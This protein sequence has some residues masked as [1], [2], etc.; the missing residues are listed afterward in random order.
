[1]ILVFIVVGAVLVFAIAAAFVGREAFRL[2]HTPTTTVFD[3][4]EAVVYVAERLSDDA[5][6]GLT[7]DEVKLLLGFS[8]D[9]LR[10]KGLSARPGEEIEL[11]PTGPPVVVA[12]D[13]AVALVLGR[14]DEAELVVTDMAVLE[15]LDLLL[16]HLVDIGAVGP[17]V[18]P[19]LD[20]DH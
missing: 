13:D 17:A 8:L 6:V 15:V 10:E 16:A 5:A 11:G 19:P 20:P 9:H 12:D 3:I 7:M 14:A 4:D 18:P 1:M 2:G